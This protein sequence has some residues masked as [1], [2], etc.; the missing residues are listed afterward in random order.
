VVL[1]WSTMGAALRTLRFETIFDAGRKTIPALA[2]WTGHDPA[3]PISS[4]WAAR[5]ARSPRT[6]PD[7]GD[8]INHRV[9]ADQLRLPTG[10]R[11]RRIPCEGGGYTPYR[12]AGGA[13]TV[14]ATEGR[15]PWQYSSCWAY[16][17][18]YSSD[19]W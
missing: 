14:E 7:A 6:G 19:G 10:C 18:S 12:N 4:S 13:R 2:A 9:A 17:F 15:D 5:S 1:V 3:P 11:R 16:S 8:L